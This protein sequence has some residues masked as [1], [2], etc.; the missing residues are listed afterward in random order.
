MAYKDLLVVVDS[1]PQARDRMVVAADIAERFEAHLVG[2]YV[3]EGLEPQRRYNRP[4]SDLI[5]EAR[6]QFDSIA[7]GRSFTTEWRSASG[8]ATDVAAVHA[9]YADLTILGQLDPESEW[10]SIL[11]PRPEDVAMTAGRPI[12]I[13][14]YIGKSQPIGN[15]VLIG[16][17]ASR[18]A[19]RA[20]SDAMPF[21]AAAALVTVISIDPQQSWEGHGAVAGTDI[22]GHL[23]RHG[24]TVQI[25]RT[26]SAG[27]DVGDVLLS[28]ASD[29]GADVLVMGA[30]AHSRVRELV[31]GGTTRTI[32]A[33]MTLPTLMAH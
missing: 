22:A 5:G 26:A 31:L 9:R 17:D 27:V 7:G 21:L 20:V 19:A 18:E 16:W 3:T 11:C 13:V 10:A 6:A 8:F 12:L 1:E 25:E 15:N 32:L 33:S 14:P 30:Y 28:R 29:L 23:A 4:C 2:L 24:V